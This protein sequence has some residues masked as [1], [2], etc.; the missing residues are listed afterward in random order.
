MVILSGYGHQIK[1]T[2]NQIRR[3]YK[4]GQSNIF[5]TLFREVKVQPLKCHPIKEKVQKL[6]KTLI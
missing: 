2:A 1:R 4:N 3:F 5:V 6:T